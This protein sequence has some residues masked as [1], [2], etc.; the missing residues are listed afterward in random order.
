MI[1]TS[2]VDQRTQKQVAVLLFVLLQ[3][4]KVYDILAMGTDPNPVKFLVKYGLLDTA[5][6]WLLR[7][8]NIDGLR[9]GWLRSLFIMVVMMAVSST[10]V[11]LIRLPV[12]ASI[13]A[14]WTRVT[15]LPDLSIQGDI[16]TGNLVDMDAHFI[17]R[18]T[19]N[20]LP[21]SLARFNPFGLHLVCLDRAHHVYQVPIEF[22]TTTTL[23]LVQIQHIT[24][25]NDVRYTNY[26]GRKLR[27]MLK[28]DY[29]HLTTEVGFKDD[30]H[31]FYLEVPVTEPGVYRLTLVGDKHGNAIRSYF[32]EFVISACP[33]VQVLYPFDTNYHCIGPEVGDINFPLVE[34][35]GVAPM[36]VEVDIAGNH[37]NL[38]LG[39]VIRS[40]NDFSWLQPIVA[41][42]SAAG[43]LSQ[44]DF[45]SILG[46]NLE[47]SVE[48]HLL[49]ITDGLRNTQR[50]NPHYHGSDVWFKYQLRKSPLFELVDTTPGVELVGGGSKTLRV[51]TT[52]D[53]FPINV[54]LKHGET[55]STHTFK[56]TSELQAGIVI[57]HE[58]S[59]SI[60]S[61]S[62]RHCDG[63]V[64]GKS[65]S[66]LL[67]QPPTIDIHAA[68]IE[69]KCLGTIGYN[70]DFDF[71]GKPP[72]EIEYHVYRNHLGQLTPVN[73]AHNVK[74]T[75]AH[76]SLEFKPLLNGNYVVKFSTLSDKLH[77][78]IAVDNTNTYGT[79]FNQVSLVSLQS[80][81][82]F[83][84]C[85][86]QL[87]LVPVKFNG[88]SPYHFSYEIINAKSGKQVYIHENATVDGDSYTIDI[89]QLMI[90]NNPEVKLRVVDAFDKF[91][92]SATVDT[93]NV[94]IKA[95]TDIPEITFAE[96][97]EYIIAEGSLV[98]VPLK[99][100]SSVGPSSNDKV[101]VNLSD[102]EGNFIRKL[103][104]ASME[105]LVATEEGIYKL[106]SFSNGGCIGKVS[107]ESKTI[108]VKFYPRPT[109]DIS[110]SNEIKRD[111]G[112]VVL[113]P[114]CPNAAQPLTL[115]LHGKAPFIVD[116][117]VKLP[118][119]QVESLLQRIMGDSEELPLPTNEGGEVV[120]EIDRVWDSLYKRGKS[121]V[122][123]V[124]I[125][126]DFRVREQPNI[127]FDEK[128]HTMCANEIDSSN[129]VG[130]KLDG[131]NP[132]LVTAIVSHNGDEPV[133]I[134]L[135]NVGGSWLELPH[136]QEK[137]SVGSHLVVITSITDKNGC[138]RDQFDNIDE[139][140]YSV[141]V[142]DTPDIRKSS[143][144]H[145]YCVGDHVGYNL[146]GEPPFV[147]DYYFG[148]KI[149][150]ATV[151]DEF[152]RLATKPGVMQITSLR[153]SSPN[154]CM[155]VF[156][157]EKAQNLELVVHDIP[158]VKVQR[159]DYI[160]EDIHEGEYT[161]LR[162]LFSGIPPFSLTYVRT[163]VIQGS[164]QPH[165]L[166]TFT[167]DDI[168]EYDYSVKASLEGSYLATR[169]ADKYCVAFRKVGDGS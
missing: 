11:A 62:N 80:Q 98:R 3:L 116:Y 84:L 152:V 104:V 95:R 67:A 78:A 141:V 145:H 103:S 26:T 93:G 135:E 29:T 23:G 112:S 89:P 105:G 68:P 94:F 85:Y 139:I 123:Y 42:E 5:F 69:D 107:D 162:F 79:Y 165:I 97:K 76:D 166:E 160:T 25:T 164:R 129:N 143:D 77:R 122:D 124:G 7:L 43:N 46:K 82:R 44:I 86:N 21:D 31:V 153:D 138:F 106:A 91:D 38:T 133:P 131:D 6:V 136:W 144:Q 109:I 134:T 2:V 157:E 34:A 40:N 48:F 59:Y 140:T 102:L 55:I 12:M 24:T 110:S 17:G 137:L 169:I 128:Y 130:I 8:S 74:T 126:A 9:F 41:T 114:V 4:W 64:E 159:G 149:R 147:V 167:V 142:T 53:E 161:D 92:C 72:F 66:I 33:Q 108:T 83:N 19:I 100:K 132:F 61:G 39:E 156:S 51:K 127:K 168:W 35:N 32:S 70:F 10:L 27:L 54:E 47:T 16:V 50:F 73:G 125:T 155:V 117:K 65:I 121:R 71:T 52:T 36:E 99:W 158:S 88:N 13:M 14:V 1:P 115:N 148:D 81:K 45:K 60:V 146:T 87:A 150:R 15:N 118:L 22:N 119:G 75:N 57:N 101:G 63:V 113:G 20:Y 49:S 151:G 163:T 18:L 120:I 154:Q 96:S 28:R 30:D 37:V 90:Q 58:G 111:N 56:T